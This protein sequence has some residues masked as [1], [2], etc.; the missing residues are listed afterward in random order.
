MV[1][2]SA[3]R[4]G[5]WIGRRSIASYS[6]QVRGTERAAVLAHVAGQ[7]RRDLAATERLGALGAEAL[8]RLG[9]FGEAEDVALAER[10]SLGRVELARPRQPLVDRPEDLEDVGLLGVD[11]R[12]LAGEPHAGPDQLAQRRG[13]EAPQRQL[14][15]RRRARHAAGGRTD[16][17]RLHGLGVEVDRHRRQ[18]DPALGPVLARRGDE[19][20]DQGRLLPPAHHHEAAGA[21]AGQRALDREG[22]EH[23]GDRG[24]DRIAALAQHLGARLGGEGMPRRDDA[25]HRRALAG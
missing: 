11:R 25:A 20:V 3:P 4:N 22:G 16:V 2:T 13:A 15:P 23:R 19:E 9:Q 5:A 24:V 18:L 8:Q 7:R 1:K 12:A 6:R 14:Q 17:E 21:E 10:P